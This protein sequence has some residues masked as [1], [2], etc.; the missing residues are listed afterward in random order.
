MAINE[1]SKSEENIKPYK[2]Q[3]YAGF[4]G[5]GKEVGELIERELNGYK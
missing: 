1:M 4:G 3:L 5:G 2:V